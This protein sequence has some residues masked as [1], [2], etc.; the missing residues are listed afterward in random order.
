MP[1]VPNKITID[2]RRHKVFIDGVEFPWFIAERGPE[3]EDLANRNGLPIVTIPIIAADVEVIP[4]D[5]QKSVAYGDRA[6]KT[7]ADVMKA[8]DD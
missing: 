5:G 3:V 8:L 1:E 4:S 6:G 2:R 7:S